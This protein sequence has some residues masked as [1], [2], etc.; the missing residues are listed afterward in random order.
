MDEL[1]ADMAR[2]ALAG[3]WLSRDD[4]LALAAAG[5]EHPNELMYR[6]NRLRTARFATAVRLC[7]IIPGKLGA[8]GEDCKWCAQSARYP[9][10][11]QPK[12]STSDDILAAGRRARRRGASSLGIVNSGRGPTAADIS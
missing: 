2:R 6:A 1:I 3:E 5:Q 10:G 12:A 8:C 11:C 7:S 9:A 4:L